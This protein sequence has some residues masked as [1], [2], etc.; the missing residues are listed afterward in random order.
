MPEIY[1]RWLSNLNH[2]LNKY[3][4]FGNVEQSWSEIGKEFEKMGRKTGGCGG[5]PGIIPS[6]INT[7]NLWY[8]FNLFGKYPYSFSLT[9]PS[10]L[11]D[12]LSA[13]IPAHQVLP[14]NFS[15][16]EVASCFAE[17]SLHWRTLT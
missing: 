7:C 9:L 6:V 12:R 17:P 15:Q 3:N 5:W 8:L 14:S 4:L 11:Y 13:L 10:N 1:S 16:Q 2:S